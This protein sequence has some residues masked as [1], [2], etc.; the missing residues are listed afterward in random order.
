MGALGTDIRVLCVLPPEACDKL[1]GK[2]E[3][4]TVCPA[5]RPFPSWDFCLPFLIPS[6]TIPHL[7]ETEGRPMESPF[8][9]SLP[10][11]QF[12]PSSPPLEKGRAFPP[13]S[14][15]THSSRP[16]SFPISTGCRGARD[17]KGGHP[18]TWGH[19]QLCC[20]LKHATQ[21][22]GGGRKT[23]TLHLN[24]APQP[25]QKTPAQA[26]LGQLWPGTRSVNLPSPTPTPCR[27]YP[28]LAPSVTRRKH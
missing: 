21:Q 16:S 17:G 4:R 20:T 24:S 8:A 9:Y 10:S 7:P 15:S 19:L 12:L 11:F 5:Q 22:V 1:R 27:P 26:F 23:S 13:S 28:G 2:G 18:A 3:A 25:E 6:P 14:T